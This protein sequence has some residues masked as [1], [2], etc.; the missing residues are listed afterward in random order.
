MTMD[1]V[2]FSISDATLDGRAVLTVRG[3]L[4]LATAPELEQALDEQLSR[5]VDVVL[6]L[7]ELDFMDSTGVRILVTAHAAAAAA[8]RRFALVRPAPDSA[9]AKILSIAGLD[10]QLVLVDDPAELD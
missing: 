10:A 5:S 3:E 2:P 1:P 8:G 9:V 4:D 6:D 7:R